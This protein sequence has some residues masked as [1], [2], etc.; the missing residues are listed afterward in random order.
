M[1]SSSTSCLSA[2]SLLESRFQRAKSYVSS[3]EAAQRDGIEPTQDEK[4]RVKIAFCG[5]LDKS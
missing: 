5:L 1:S 4:L 3:P 2:S